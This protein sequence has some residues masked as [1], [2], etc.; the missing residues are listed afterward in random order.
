MRSILYIIAVILIIGWAVGTFAYAASGLIHVLLV[1]ALISIILG[2]LRRDNIR[3]KNSCPDFLLPVLVQG[4]LLMNKLIT[5]LV[6]VKLYIRA[7]SSNLVSFTES[8][9]LRFEG[10]VSPPVVLSTVTSLFEAFQ[11][12][13]GSDQR[14][15]ISG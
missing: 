12:V 3:N 11:K 2:F 4:L 13:K 9:V 8:R 7:N 5:F 1:I 6:V 15:F 14:K 10:G